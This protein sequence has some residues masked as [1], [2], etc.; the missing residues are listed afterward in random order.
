MAITLIKTIFL[1]R[2]TIVGQIKTIKERLRNMPIT[3]I[4]LADIAKKMEQSLIQIQRLASKDSYEY[5]LP[6]KK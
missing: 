2:R 4:G 5:L 1:K 3:Y 6:W